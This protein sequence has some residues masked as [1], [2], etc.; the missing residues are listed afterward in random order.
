MSE[1]NEYRAYFTL[2][3][4]F[5]P[6]AITALLDI[7]PTRCWRKGDL[8]VRSG[9]EYT[10]SRWDLESSLSRTEEIAKHIE[11]VLVRLSPVSELVRRLSLEHE[12]YIQCVAYFSVGQSSLDVDA[13]LVAKISA[14]G[15]GINL[16][17]YDLSSRNEEI[18]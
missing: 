12:G 14:L 3:G 10:F 18:A 16:D 8:N 15:L 6:P 2:T 11:D 5:D 7:Q 9:R 4:D 1:N 17:P 13:W